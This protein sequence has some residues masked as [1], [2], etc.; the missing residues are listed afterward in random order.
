MNK[1]LPMSFLV[2]IF[3]GCAT[4]TIYS[5]ILDTWPGGHVDKLYTSWGQPDRSSTVSDGRQIIEYNQQSNVQ[6]G[7][8]N[9]VDTIVTMGPTTNSGM[10]TTEVTRQAPIREV[11]MWCTTTFIANSSGIITG[12]SSKGNNCRG[13]PAR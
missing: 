5:K 11:N 7:G 10:E 1:L 3:A 6:S 12:A 9:Y 13:K 4:N 8:Y 2:L